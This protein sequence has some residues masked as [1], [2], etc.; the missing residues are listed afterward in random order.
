MPKL[1][2]LL[3]TVALGVIA[4][5]AVQASPPEDALTS[6]AVLSGEV[7]SVDQLTLEMGPGRL[8]IS[9]GNLYAAAPVEGASREFV[10]VGHAR[11][12]L[13]PPD[14]IER[15]QLEFFIDEP[16]LDEEILSA[17][18][19]IA[20]DAAL[21][22]ISARPPVEPSVTERS[23]ARST[24]SSWRASPDRD[25]TGVEAALVR[26]A[27]ADPA[28]DQYF[29][30]WMFSR[31]RGRFVYLV[32][33]EAYEQVTLGRFERVKLSER[34]R[35]RLERQLHREQ[36]QGRLIGA[37]VRHLGRFDTWM[38]MHMPTPEGGLRPGRPT[39]DVDH[40]DLELEVERDARHVRGRA[41]ITLEAR[42]PTTVLRF[43][44]HTDLEVESVLGADGELEFK[45]SG[46][47]LLVLLPRQLEPGQPLKVEIAYAGS[48]IDREGS[49]AALKHTLDWYPNTGTNDR[50][51]FDVEFRWPAR[52]D[53]L[54]S[55]RVVEA[56]EEGDQRWQRTVLRRP[57]SAFGFEV[58]K[59]RSE[60]FEIRGIPVTFATDYQGRVL[61]GNRSRETLID[62]IAS[63]LEFCIDTFGEYP[64]EQLT[65]VTTGRDFSQSLPGFITLSSLMLADDTWLALY[66]DLDD[67]R[68]LIAHEIAHQWWG[69]RVTFAGYR[70]A[71]LSEGM[72]NYAATLYVRRNVPNLRFGRGPTSGWHLALTERLDDGTT[73]EQI[74]P[75][76]L[77]KRLNSSRAS[78][79]EPI[80][81]RKGAL[82]LG[83]LARGVG[84]ER[85][86]EA[87]R[88]LVEFV[89]E[90]DVSLTTSDFV[91]LLSQITQRPIHGFAE[92]FVFSTGLPSINYKYEI[93]PREDGGWKVL[94]EIAHQSSL[95]FTYRVLEVAPGVLDVERQIQADIESH[96]ATLYLPFRILLA[97]DAD[98]EI[99][100]RFGLLTLDSENMA[101]E[102]DL[103][104]EPAGFELD[105]HDEVFALSR[106]LSFYPKR[107]QLIR[108]LEELAE[109]DPDAARESFLRVLSVAT[110]EGDVP[111]SARWLEDEKRTYDARAHRE[112][113]RLALRDGNLEFAAEQ[114]A[115]A[116]R[117][118]SFRQRKGLN[119]K[120]L[121]ARLAL[122]RGEAEEALKH[123]EKDVY[124]SGST[125]VEANLVFVV[126][127]IQ[128]GR[129]QE[130]RTVLARLH[131]QPVDIT[132]LSE[133]TAG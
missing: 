129:R 55:G 2:I 85:F 26:D 62:A 112:L 11:F 87:L 98:D 18:L 90:R 118:M 28:Y 46:G 39:L 77:G 43:G 83:M 16:K 74:G 106:N 53:L 126:A 76:T 123:L 33:P 93:V 73:L 122:R 24:Y 51:T 44:L 70:E 69:H 22:A 19:V 38:S 36:R 65:L 71:W 37:D 50:A 109:G 30:A 17:V 114:L 125:H 45:E 86:L 63:A 79:Y 15:G 89:D 108:G 107:R 3:Q 130:A 42:S 95:A 5:V 61:T 97:N 133:R 113:C 102:F 120:V 40:Y 67:P 35:R 66:S 60:V 21:A 103:D 84:E 41:E 49:S 34:D 81:Y 27:H 99:R 59:F 110:Y 80:V 52:F 14:D 78:A 31:A 4:G 6:A 25:V 96:D 9:S 32:D 91:A 92:Q 88:I 7:F 54:S 48:L 124:R 47:E 116:A 101:F 12:R 127:A 58:G 57:S 75:L 128:A 23:L 111:I 94:G 131:E 8:H 20:S 29:C 64:F 105:P 121:E 68:G 82:V 10:L 1:R 100:Y 117:S 56:G 72:A 119:Y 13:D 104:Q 132:W 115:Q